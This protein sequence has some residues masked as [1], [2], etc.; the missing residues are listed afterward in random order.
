MTTR[1]EVDYVYNPQFTSSSGPDSGAAVSFFFRKDAIVTTNGSKI[2]KLMDEKK[3]LEFKL[4]TVKCKIK[5]LTPTTFGEQL[6][7]NRLYDA[8]L[9]ELRHL[10]AE[11]D[12][13]IE[14]LSRLEDE[15]VSLQQAA[16]PTS[17]TSQKTPKQKLIYDRVEQLLRDD[18]GKSKAQCF[19]IVAGEFDM[20]DAA[21]HERYNQQQRKE[22]RKKPG[23]T[24]GASK[25]DDNPDKKEKK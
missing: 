23:G 17:T 21:V 12:A 18:P 7:F 25:N 19:S 2:Q 10:D 16:K 3:E 9:H 1:T 4:I 8:R 13:L 11:R 20:S 14:Q 24:P 5:K 6:S 15:I 22:L